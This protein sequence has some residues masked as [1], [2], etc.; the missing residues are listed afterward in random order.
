[1]R[2]QLAGKTNLIGNT[3]SIG[4]GCSPCPMAEKTLCNR[5]KKK[6][7][8]FYASTQSLLYE[9]VRAYTRYPVFAGV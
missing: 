8:P 5:R 2:H 4:P 7:N 3:R 1:M 9:A 6:G